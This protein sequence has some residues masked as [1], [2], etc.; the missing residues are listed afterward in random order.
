MN[1]ERSNSRR[2]GH[3]EL[4]LY[5]VLRGKLC[6]LLKRK[7]AEHYEL[8]RNFVQVSG[9]CGPQSARAQFIVDAQTVTRIQDS[10]EIVERE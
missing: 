6:V 10:G 1:Y 3:V 8:D 7:K 5:Y 9:S 2:Q 4:M